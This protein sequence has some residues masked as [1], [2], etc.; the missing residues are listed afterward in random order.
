MKRALA[1]AM[2]LP[3]CAVRY[4]GPGDPYAQPPPPPPAY[5]PPP[6]QP[7]PPPPAYAPVPQPA[8][9]PPAPRRLTRD[10][11]VQLAWQYAAQRGLQLCHVRGERVRVHVIQQDWRTG[12][13][14]RRGH[15][16]A[17]VGGYRNRR[18]GP[19]AQHAE[20]RRGQRS[21]AAVRQQHRPRSIALLEE[22][23]HSRFVLRRPTVP[24]HS[25][26]DAGEQR[27]GGQRRVNGSLMSPATHGRKRTNR[28]PRRFAI[29]NGRRRHRRGPQENAG[30]SGEGVAFTPPGAY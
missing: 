25:G 18:A 21:R 14:R 29:G 24:C 23:R 26:P 1:L 22:R 9:P 12:A 27:R 10:Q 2:A 20:Q 13:I 3:A 5:S 30:S 11:A 6:A 4:A 28:G 7:P 8:P 16:E 17:R 15:V 19:S